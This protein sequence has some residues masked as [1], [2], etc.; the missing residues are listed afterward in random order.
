MGMRTPR[1]TAGRHAGDHRAKRLRQIAHP[2]AI[3]WARSPAPSKQFNLRREGG[4][5]RAPSNTILFSIHTASIG[6]TSTGGGSEPSATARLRSSMRARGAGCMARRPRRRPTPRIP[7]TTLSLARSTAYP[8]SNRHS[9]AWRRS[10]STSSASATPRR[11]AR[12]AS[13]ST[14]R[15]PR[16]TTES[17][18]A[19][20]STSRAPTGSAVTTRSTTF[21]TV[22]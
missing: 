21:C 9:R 16:T 8:S 14:R 13:S 11:L 10:S 7:S 1:S 22:C 15:R 20:C 6:P 19:A 2:D 18:R 5:T 4:A 17:S 3:D 12:A